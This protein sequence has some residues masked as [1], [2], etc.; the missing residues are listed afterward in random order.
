MMMLATPALLPASCLAML[1]QKFSSAITRSGPDALVVVAHPASN[2]AAA[3]DGAIR[4][5]LTQSPYQTNEIESHSC[6]APV[7]ATLEAMAAVD[8]KQHVQGKLAR[9]GHARGGAR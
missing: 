5:R 7:R 3:I 1:P 4:L 6:S 9:S 8:W 2:A